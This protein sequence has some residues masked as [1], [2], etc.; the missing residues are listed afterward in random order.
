MF[1]RSVHTFRLPKTWPWGENELVNKRLRFCFSTLLK[2]ISPILTSVPFPS[3]LARS[4][5][6]HR[7]LCIQMRFMDA[8]SPI[9]RKQEKEKGRERWR[10]RALA[11]DVALSPTVR[12]RTW[13]RCIRT[14]GCNKRN[15]AR[16]KSRLALL[17]QR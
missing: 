11:R 9:L 14:K 8:F 7:C 10:G 4:Y 17:S 5:N 3:L 15:S 6:I 16:E 1:T 13:H 12:S 2:I